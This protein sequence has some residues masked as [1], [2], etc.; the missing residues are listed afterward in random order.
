MANTPDEN[1]SLSPKISDRVPPSLV[2]AAAWG[3]RLLI[4]G[5]VV[6][7]I[8]WLGT[9]FLMVVISLLAALLLAVIL[10][11]LMSFL[12]NRWK[13]RPAAASG[14]LLLGLLIFIFGLLGGSGTAIYHGVSEIW[15]NVHRGLDDFVFQ[16][17]Q[18][19]P[20]SEEQITRAFNNTLNLAQKNSNKII[21]GVATIG[22]SVSTVLAGMILTFFTLFFFLKD[23]RSIWHWIVRLFP[24]ESRTTVNESGIRAWIT[25]GN[26][27]RTQI[28]VAFVDALGIALTAT[29]LKTP[30][31][32]VIPI[33]VIVFLGSFV[34]ILGAFF[35]GSV[36]VLVVFVN[37]GNLWM[38]ILMLVGVLLVQQ[39]EGNL[40]LPI[41][42]GNALNMHP[43]AVVL[44][45]TS[46]SIVAGI[47]GA[48]FTVPAAAALNTIVLYLKGH[49]L[50]PYLDTD[51]YRPGG[52][53][54]DFAYY[55]AQ[56]W[57]QFDDKIPQ[58]LSPQER[59]KARKEKKNKS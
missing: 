51:P 4:I 20:A 55:S 14:L 26:Y 6:A 45:V 1:I 59:R 39:I 58:R 49:D 42:Q 25:L 30:L 54:Q 3:W 31:N 23:G 13:M 24:V 56:H 37:T 9:K 28:I 7:G 57:Q 17:N 34:P 29:I 41:L 38:A 35:S 12:C 50:Y 44:L 32:L 16:L 33:G 43:L 22:A 2:L 15:Y 46:G 10:E 53:K 47:F 48:L 27:A 18:M 40:L 8:I 5:L 19:F 52:A 11:P 21:G 36:A